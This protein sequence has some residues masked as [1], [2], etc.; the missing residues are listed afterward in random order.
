MPPESTINR[1]APHAGNST[2]AAPTESTQPESRADLD[3]LLL[4]SAGWIEQA[5]PNDV[6]F[7]NTS[8]RQ[9][10]T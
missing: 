2:D 3:D 9:E 8:H 5:Y 4:L 10:E 6:E 7:F 1:A